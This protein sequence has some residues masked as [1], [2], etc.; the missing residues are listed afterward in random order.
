MNKDH[1]PVPPKSEELVEDNTLPSR[2]HRL[3]MF[4]DGSSMDCSSM[5]RAIESLTKRLDAHLMEHHP[6]KFSYLHVKDGAVVPPAISDLEDV[7]EALIDLHDTAMDARAIL[8]GQTTPID[9]GDLVSLLTER[10]SAARAII[11]KHKK[12]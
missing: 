5:S 12:P 4:I 3:E 10:L 8:S 7:L 11:T 6:I 2:V 1:T 9:K